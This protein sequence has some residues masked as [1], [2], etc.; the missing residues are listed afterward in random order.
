MIIYKIRKLIFL[1][2]QNYLLKRKM[3]IDNIKIK[4]KTNSIK[5]VK[6]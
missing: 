1:T 3:I 4:K 5:D 2:H 6:Q